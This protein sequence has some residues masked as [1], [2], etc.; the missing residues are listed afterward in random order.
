[1]RSSQFSVTDADENSRA[2]L[3]RTYRF[4]WTARHSQIYPELRR[5]TDLGAPPVVTAGVAVGVAVPGVFLIARY[6]RQLV[7]ESRVEVAP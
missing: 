2:A 5:L 7:R 4:Y 3:A 6:K 1:L